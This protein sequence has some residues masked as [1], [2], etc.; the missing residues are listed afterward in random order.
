MFR[1]LIES[2]FLFDNSD[3]VRLV[4]PYK[5]MEDSMR[6]FTA[7]TCFAFVACVM[8]IPAL[9]APIAAQQD[10]DVERPTSSLAFGN[11]FDRN[12]KHAFEQ[13]LS[14]DERDRLISLKSR[15]E[16]A[17][18]ENPLPTSEP[19]QPFYLKL[20]ADMTREFA[21]ALSAAGCS[22]VGYANSHTH[23]VRARDADSLSLGKSLIVGHP[24]VVG[25]L[26]QTDADMMSASVFERI[27]NGFDLAGFYSVLFWRDLSIEQMAATLDAAGAVIVDGQLKGAAPMVTVRVDNAGAAVLRGH[28]NI[29]LLNLPS[30]RVTTNVTSAAMSSADPATI[31]VA[32]YN[33]D[34]TGEV[35]GVWDAG[36]ALETH[37]DYQTT[38]TLPAGWGS[39]SRI[40]NRNSTSTRA[41][42]H[43][44][45]G[46]TPPAITATVIRRHRRP[47]GAATVVKLSYAT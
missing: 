45:N 4:R 35:A 22:F 32:P 23:F 28:Q 39:A 31:G 42:Q 24:L 43:A 37:L 47:T 5:L 3:P 8:A 10:P 27:S 46:T 15:Y 2:T 21:D 29:E 12:A 17:D 20:R 16:L 36:I 13:Q 38:N 40:W 19:R 9:R 1:T 44:M 11:A 26:L 30:T 33:L 7:W 25:T 18:P 6:P 14:S 41:G 34:G